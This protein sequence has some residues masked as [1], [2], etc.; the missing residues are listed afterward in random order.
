[1]GFQITCL[2]EW[3][4]KFRTSVGFSPVWILIRL[5][6]LGFLA[7]LRI[8]IHWIWIRI[9][10][11]CPI[12]IRIRGYAINFRRKNVCFFNW[13]KQLSL[14]TVY[15]LKTFLT[16]CYLNK[17]LLCLYFLLWISILNITSFSFILSSIYMCGSRSKKLLNTDTLR[18]RI[19]NTAFWDWTTLLFLLFEGKF[20]RSV[21]F[22]YC[23]NPH[24]PAEAFWHCEGFSKHWTTILYCFSPQWE[25]N[26]LWRLLGRVNGLV[27]PVQL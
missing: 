20:W 9:Q 5:T 2:A 19:H 11:F 10:V 1:M 12:W 15:F 24:E 18:I 22:L 17:F 6:S 23:V 26:W 16:K 3:L 8:Q 13:E 14:K 25:F 7:V 27:H 21:G 4:G